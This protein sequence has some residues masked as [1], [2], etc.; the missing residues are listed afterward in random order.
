MRNTHFQRKSPHDGAPEVQLD[1]SL[2]HR[3]QV[4]FHFMGA[5]FSLCESYSAKEA[6]LLAAALLIA[7]DSCESDLCG[8][9]CSGVA[10]TSPA[11]TGCPDCTVSLHD[12]GCQ[13]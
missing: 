5:G 2:K 10:C 7:A 12:V 1:T 13:E 3:G 6:R 4:F 9:V 8:K 11:G